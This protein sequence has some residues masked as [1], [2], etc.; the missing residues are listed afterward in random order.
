MKVLLRKNVTKLGIIGD[1]VEVKPG[2]A[3]NHLLPRGLAFV[4][5]EANIK[6]VEAERQKYLEQVASERAEMEAKAAAVNGKEATITAAANEQGHLY[7]SVGPAQIA[8]AFIAEGIFLETENI[9]LPEPLR[10]LDKYD[11]TLRFAEDVTATVHVWIVPAQTADV[12]GEG[13]GAEGEAAEG[14]APASAGPDQPAASD[15]AEKP[16]AE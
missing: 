5:S 12:E 2:Y 15:E 6:A 16:D 11:V 3:R 4:P 8:A 7:G 13:E 1:I 9:V 14:Q 10:Q